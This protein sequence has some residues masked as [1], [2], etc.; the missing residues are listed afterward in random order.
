MDEIADFSEYEAT[1]RAALLHTQRVAALW[2][3]PLLADE[4]VP[5]AVGLAPSSWHAIKAR[6][7]GPVMFNIG[8]RRFVLSADLRAWLDGL[9]AKTQ[10]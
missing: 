9:R 4:E 2:T 6:G 1:A 7:E 10:K 8:R 3:K 5:A